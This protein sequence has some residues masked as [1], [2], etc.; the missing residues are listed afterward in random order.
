M[1]LDL[2]SILTAIGTAIILW[3]G[4]TVYQLDKTVSL[5]EYQIQQTNKVLQMLVEEK[6]D[7]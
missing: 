5:L 4:S 1:K 6:K 7:K 2:P 3:L